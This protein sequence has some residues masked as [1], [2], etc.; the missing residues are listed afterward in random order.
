MAAAAAA[1]QLF[2]PEP[3]IVAPAVAYMSVRRGLQQLH[4]RGHGEV[5]W[6]DVTDRRRARRV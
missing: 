2:P 3:A 5:R 1:I 4:D 6:V